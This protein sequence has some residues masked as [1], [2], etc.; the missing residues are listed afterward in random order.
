M[1]KLIDTK[2]D[3]EI[4]VCLDEFNNFHVI[5]GAGSGKT[6]SLIVALS[7][8]REK[9]AKN[10]RR[11]GQ[12]VVCITYTKRAVAVISSRLDFDDLFVISTLHSFLWEQIKR[13]SP[14][15]RTTLLEKIIPD[16][17][18]KKKDDDNGGQSKKAIKAR[19][20]IAELTAHLE[21]VKNL[22]SFD[23]NDS[24]YSNF[25]T[26]ELGH[27][28][29]INT[30]AH[31]LMTYPTLRKLIS[32]KYPFIFVD[33]AQDTFDNVVQALNEVCKGDG[34]PIVGYFGD[35][36]QQIYDKRAGNFEGPPGSKEITK[37]ENFRCSCSVI[38]LLNS[39][40]KDVE[41]FPAGENADVPGSVIIRLI[42]AEEPQAP[43][44]RYSPDQL[45]R[46]S[47][48]YDEAITDWGWAETSFKGLFLVRQMIARRLGFSG[49][50]SLFTGKYSS[51]SSQDDYEAG[52]HYLLKP[53]SN[54]LVGLIA[55][56]TDGNQREM[57]DILRR[58]SPTFDPR[59]ENATKKL[60]EMK[61]M[62]EKIVSGLAKVWE[63]GSVGEILK[64]SHNHALFPFSDRLIDHLQR[65]PR[66][67]EYDD[68]VHS[69]DKG[70]WLV[71]EFFSMTKEEI[72]PYCNFISENTPYSTQH[73][74]KGEEYEN[75]VVVFDDVE[76]A[77]N[78]YS[79]TKLLTPSTSGAPTESQ[80]ER[81]KK[82]AYVCFSRAEVNLRIMLFT[83]DTKSAAS[84]LIEQGFF[85]DGQIEVMNL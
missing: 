68:E 12:K 25:E 11:D 9:H 37:E 16:H 71:D 26:G 83:R 47:S 46:A 62:A 73:G 5:A 78:R 49:L 20:K 53:F 64:Y 36:M 13:F 85:D 14:D 28:D 54:C 34:L 77:W 52:E 30:A 24:N 44:K 33:E 35:P 22:T 50:N 51:S 41:Q 43:R 57:I 42:E 84:E 59:G 23:Y 72:A 7:Y 48:K 3:K 45:D 1:T 60:G 67:E 32:Q 8:L 82:L 56:H 75:V 29:V 39:F 40:R 63:E 76:A 58:N 27:D 69:K 15:I 70:D 55:A 21:I 38:S 66:E 2:A 17:I 65:P 10:L 79:F 31:M 18:A 4:R 81:S 6:T 19:E 61:S 80:L 74:V